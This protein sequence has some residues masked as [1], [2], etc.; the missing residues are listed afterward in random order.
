MQKQ[1]SAEREITREKIESMLLE[2][3]ESNKGG[4]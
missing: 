1:D 3:K 4:F 2:I